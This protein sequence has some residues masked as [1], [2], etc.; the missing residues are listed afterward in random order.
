M[1]LHLGIFFIPS[2]RLLSV[3][4]LCRTAPEVLEGHSCTKNSDVYSYGML[5]YEIAS[6]KDPYESISTFRAEMLVKEGKRI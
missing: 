2:N 6:R 1:A 4:F 5:L 3:P